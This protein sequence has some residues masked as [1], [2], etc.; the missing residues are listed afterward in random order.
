M[1]QPCI[2]GIFLGSSLA[3]KD[4][5]FIQLLPQLCHS[6]LPH[7][8]RQEGPLPLQTVSSVKVLCISLFE[9]FFLSLIQFKGIGYT[10]ELKEFSNLNHS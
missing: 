1:L 5:S 3:Y 2:L 8:L 7:N 9:Q 6:H 4:A 10:F